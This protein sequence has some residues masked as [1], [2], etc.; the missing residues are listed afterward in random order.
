VKQNNNKNITEN[1][2]SLM[3]HGF[4]FRVDKIPFLFVVSCTIDQISE[5]KSKLIIVEKNW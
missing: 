1:H 3:V 5:S 2:S 4:Y